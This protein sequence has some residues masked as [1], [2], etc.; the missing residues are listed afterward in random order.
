[1]KVLLVET[2]TKQKMN[3][4]YSSIIAK[5]GE[6]MTGLLAW[7]R[8]TPRILATNQLHIIS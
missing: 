4:E 2:T 3:I 6:D 5:S 7:A 8:Q 1:M